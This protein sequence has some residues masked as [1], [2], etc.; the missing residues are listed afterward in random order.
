MWGPFSEHS[1]I[2]GTGFGRSS[3]KV[4]LILFALIFTP[5]SYVIIHGI[6][7]AAQFRALCLI[8]VLVLALRTPIYHHTVPDP[9]TSR[10]HTAMMAGD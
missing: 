3:A 8:G 6:R 5:E 4:Y 2:A 10:E 1:R 7:Y 9:T